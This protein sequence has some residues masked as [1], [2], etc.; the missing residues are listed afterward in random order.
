MHQSDTSTL[1]SYLLFSSS[2]SFPCLRS[3]LNDTSIRCPPTSDQSLLF[4]C[5][6]LFIVCINGSL[7]LVIN[8]NL[9]ITRFIIQAFNNLRHCDNCICLKALEVFYFIQGTLHTALADFHTIQR[10]HQTDNRHICCTLDLRN[11]LFHGLA[12]CCYIFDHHNTITV[13]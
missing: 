11:S 1:I 13:L 2:L 10:N 4:L 7:Q 6:I 8:H 5:T 3:Y 12:G 9:P